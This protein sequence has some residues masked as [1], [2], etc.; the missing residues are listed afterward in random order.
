MKRELRELFEYHSDIIAWEI[1]VLIT[2]GMAVLFMARAANSIP[3]D[4]EKQ[5]K[6]TETH[7]AAPERPG[8][9]AVGP[10]KCAIDAAPTVGKQDFIAMRQASDPDM[11][12]EPGTT[13]EEKEMQEGKVISDS[14]IRI[15]D[16]GRITGVT[17]RERHLLAKIVQAECETD[18]IRAKMLVAN[19][20][21]NRVR[22]PEFPSGIEEVI[23][24]AG[25]FSPVT[26]GR[27][28]AS[29]PDD[30]CFYAVDAVLAGWDESEGATYFRQTADG[31]TWHDRALDYVTESGT[32]TFYRER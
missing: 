9:A 13:D 11:A 8:M 21:L 19:T 22:D 3:P 1:I 5:G 7:Y 20:V 6:V 15:H 32:T 27:W 30:T 25:Q 2:L 18:P 17:R 10:N 16:D 26:D 23:F 12:E 4:T 29:K 24:Q 14:G 28:E 31:N